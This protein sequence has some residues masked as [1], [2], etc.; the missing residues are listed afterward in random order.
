MIG[1]DKKGKNKLCQTAGETITETLISTLMISMIFM[2]IVGA[3]VTA[4]RI[5]ADNKN[6]VVVFS[7]ATTPS[8]ESI[9]LGISSGGSQVFSAGNGSMDE[10]KVTLYKTDGDYYYFEVN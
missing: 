6:E 7:H 3:V 2:I 9:S 1:K 8:T 4:A 10:N 5:N